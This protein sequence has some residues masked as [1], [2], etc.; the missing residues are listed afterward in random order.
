AA[1]LVGEAEPASRSVTCFYFAA[2]SAP[3]PHPML[4]LNGDGAGPVNN[5]AVMSQIAP[6]YAPAGQS[7]VSISVLGTHELTDQQLGGF[8][9]AQMK[10]WFGDIARSWKFLLSYRISHAD[11]RQ[12][13]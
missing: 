9:I 6:T 1:H 10:N 13:P 4:L 3:V 11:P 7:L 2:E 12:G 8:V 5:L